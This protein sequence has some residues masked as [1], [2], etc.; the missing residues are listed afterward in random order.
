MVLTSG[1]IQL[2]I[3]NTNTN[4]G[5]QSCLY[6]LFL[7]ILYYRET[8]FLRDRVGWTNPLAIRNKVNDPIV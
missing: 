6:Q 1:R 3:V 2:S 7:L 4:L 5:R 8:S